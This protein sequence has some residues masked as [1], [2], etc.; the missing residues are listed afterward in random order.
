M[1]LEGGKLVID[2]GLSWI[3]CV[4]NGFAARIETNGVPYLAQLQEDVQ[5]YSN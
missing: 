5:K 3:G 1:E 2:N 4:A